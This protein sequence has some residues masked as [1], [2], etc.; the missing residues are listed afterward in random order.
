[1]AQ[2]PPPGDPWFFSAPATGLRLEVTTSFHS[3][4]F[5]RFYP[6]YDRAFILPSEKEDEDGFRAC[7]ALNRPGRTRQALVERFGPFNE[8][9]MIAHDA[10]EGIE[11][12]G[13]NCIVL[14]YDDAEG[15]PVAS[16]NLNYI[17]VDPARRGRGYLRR[18]LDALRLALDEKLAPGRNALVF[19]EQNDP[20]RLDETAYA[21]D[22]AHAG[23]DQFDRLHV[24]ARMG[25]RILDF[26]Y[27]QPAL[28]AG[29]E[30]D[31][32]L[33]YSLLDARRTA[34]PATLLADHLERFFVLSV[35]KGRMPRD[36]AV[37]DAQLRDLRTRPA[38]A[39][40][41]ILDPSPLLERVRGQKDRWSIFKDRPA[42]LV[43]AIMEQAGAQ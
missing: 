31:A 20:F 39:Q 13:I 6:S 19:L 33:A 21:Q 34:L 40:V 1:M 25:A 29:Q 36:R 7:L 17:F 27:V 14:Q 15:R 8:Y 10:A 35:W 23:I 3:P 2:Q 22:T 30:P 26:P 12:G 42:S 24:W 38:G 4:T 32:S 43:S 5:A 18:M 16:V 41:R 28:S 37:A 9:C 11:I